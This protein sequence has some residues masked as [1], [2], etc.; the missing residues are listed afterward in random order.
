M[1]ETSPYSTATAAP[2]AKTN[3]LA[4]IALVAAFVVPLAGIICGHIALG[5]IKRSGESGRGLALAGTVLGYVFT[6][7]YVIFFVVVVG[8]Q[9]WLVSNYSY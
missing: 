5:Q 8:A 7:F 1:T 6:V 9:V 2:A 4:I 3:V